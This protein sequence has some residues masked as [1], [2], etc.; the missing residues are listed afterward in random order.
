LKRRYKGL[1]IKKTYESIHEEPKTSKIFNLKQQRILEKGVREREKLTENPEEEIVQRIIRN[2]LDIQ[3]LRLIQTQPMWGYT[4]LK[5][6]ETKYG[7]KIRHGALYPLLNSLKAKGF[8]KSKKEVKKGRIRKIY[9]ITPKGNQLIESYY[10]ALK[11]QLET[12]NLEG[13]REKSEIGS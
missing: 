5:K 6:I 4:I 2:F 12:I 13:R 9:E 8:L 1:C 7:I 10:N 11:Q 3:I